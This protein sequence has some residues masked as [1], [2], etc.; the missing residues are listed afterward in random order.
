[1]RRCKRE[2]KPVIRLTYDQPGHSTEEPVT[3][4]HH[5]MVIQLN[6]TSQNKDVETKVELYTSQE[7]VTP[8]QK[9]NFNLRSKGQG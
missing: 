1:M 7:N 9:T 3:I 5:G 6:L 2:T 4:A 8:R